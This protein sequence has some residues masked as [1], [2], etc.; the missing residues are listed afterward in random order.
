MTKACSPP[1]PSQKSLHFANEHN[2]PT[3]VDPKKRNF[4]A[5]NH[6][7][8]FKPNLKE[9]REGLKVDFNVDNPEL[10]SRLLCG[11]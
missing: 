1:N 11:I 2:V 5:Y 3:V 8:L 6:T 4:L 10:N 9:L 7:T